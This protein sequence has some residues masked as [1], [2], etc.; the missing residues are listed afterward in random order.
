MTNEQLYSLIVWNKVALFS[1]WAKKHSQLKLLVNFFPWAKKNIAK[2]TFYD[3]YLFHI[4]FFFIRD[5]VSSPKA[6]LE[7]PTKHQR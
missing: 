1:P 4:I 2:S 5:A 6:K 3:T 7:G